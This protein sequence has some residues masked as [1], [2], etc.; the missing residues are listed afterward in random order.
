MLT[1]QVVSEVSCSAL[2]SWRTLLSYNPDYS[3]GQLSTDL[4]VQEELAFAAPA[5]L[6]ELLLWATRCVH[7]RERLPKVADYASSGPERAA[8][9][10]LTSIQRETSKR[11]PNYHTL[12]CESAIVTTQRKAALARRARG[13]KRA[14][15]GSTCSGRY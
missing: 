9:E 3:P 6:L 8:S 7:Q 4:T 5:D 14:M 11:P 1:G 2:N 10:S 15:Q 13:E 12:A